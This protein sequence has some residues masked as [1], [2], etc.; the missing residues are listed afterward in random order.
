MRFIFG[1]DLPFEMGTKIYGGFE[2]EE[3]MTDQDALRICRD[4]SVLDNSSID[5]ALLAQ[6]I[7]KG[8]R[9]LFLVKDDVET[10]TLEPVFPIDPDE[11]LCFEVQIVRMKVSE[12]AMKGVSNND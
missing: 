6:Y 8:L 7:R 4:F 10:R 11:R 3:W 9:L 5:G 1:F 12:T 2:Q